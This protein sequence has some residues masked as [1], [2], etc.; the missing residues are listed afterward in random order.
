MT[1][2]PIEGYEIECHWCS[3]AGKK[4]V[5]SGCGYKE[6]CGRCRGT[7]VELTG[8]GERLLEFLKVHI[9]NRGIVIE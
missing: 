6:E 3:G 2:L 1:R 8:N 9:T 5:Y 4:E 7:G